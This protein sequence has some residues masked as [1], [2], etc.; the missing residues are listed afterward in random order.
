M[1]A[2]VR[3]RVVNG[4]TMLHNN[5]IALVIT[6]VVSIVWLRVNDYFA[7][8]GWVSSHLSR[9]IIHMGTG[10]VFVLCWLLFDNAPIAR[11]LAALVP[12]LITIQF[13]LIGLGI[14]EDEAAVKAMS[15]SGNR[16]EVLKGPLFYGIVF[17]IMT[18]LFWKESAIGMT[19]LMLMCGGDGLADILGRAYGKTHLPWAPRKTWVGSLGM[20]LGGWIFVVFII[21]VYTALGALPGS[22]TSYI[23]PV[24]VI[25][26]AG[27][28]VESL[29]LNDIDNF[30]VTFAAV[31]LGLVLFP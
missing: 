5:L 28:I 8:K 24:T 3:A 22:L 29:P 30:T 25:A 13:A 9:K 7:H 17:V 15:R 31:L 1:P 12:L 23:F 10:P 11:Y 20:L 27:T 2:Y 14:I 21:A 19:A 6:F 4:D 18:I 16:R 26:V